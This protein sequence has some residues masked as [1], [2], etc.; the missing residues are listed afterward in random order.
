M[1]I[2]EFIKKDS[3][4]R[5][6]IFLKIKCDYCGNIFFRQKRFYKFLNEKQFCSPTCKGLYN[7]TIIKITCAHC[8]KEFTRSVNKLKNSKSGIYFCCRA[9]KD[10]AQSYIKE[11]QP[12]HYGTGESN[13]R[14]KAL[15]NLPNK[16]DICG[17]SDKD[18]LI[19]HH[20]DKNRD[21]NSIKNL[22]ILCAN[23]H[24][25]IHKRGM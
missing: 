20:R 2:K 24:L 16:C 8:K 4:N 13:Y 12:N 14:S 10:K 17:I 21:N 25:K 19:V 23:C 9:C 3:E 1:F 18:V 22:Q 15:N 6:R 11:I 7:E 5:N